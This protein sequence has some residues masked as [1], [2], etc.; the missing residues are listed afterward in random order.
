MRLR[1]CDRRTVLSPPLRSSLMRD[2]QLPRPLFTDRPPRPHTPIVSLLIALA[3]L[4]LPAVASAAT[5][6][7][8]QV[9]SARWSTPFQ[10]TDGTTATD[11]RLIVETDNFIEA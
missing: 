7:S 2:K 10:C 4:L 6:F 1:A 3:L 5:G 9:A 8:E 11:G